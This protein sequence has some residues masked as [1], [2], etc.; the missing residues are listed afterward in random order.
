MNFLKGAVIF[1][2]G[3]SIG[4]TGSYI[5]FKKKYDEKK[6]ELEE[7][8]EHYQEKLNIK[9]EKETQNAIIRKAKYVSYDSTK[10][11]NEVKTMIKEREAVADL[12]SRPMEDYPEEPIVITDEDYT[13][14]ELYFD[15]I[16]TDYYVE[17]GALV[18]ENEDLLEVGDTIGY[19]NLEKFMKDE[20]EDVMYIRNA[21]RGSDYLVRKVFGKYSDVIGVGGGDD[22]E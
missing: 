1:L 17:D 2:L 8:K 19:E 6:E 14:R 15:K 7:L 20:S 16:E 9:S 21:P 12:M 18:G 11:D 13:D 10:P 3:S 22:D 5:Y 4:A